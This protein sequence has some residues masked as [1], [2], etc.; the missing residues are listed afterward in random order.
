MTR[1]VYSR[2]FRALRLHIA[3]VSVGFRRWLTVREQFYRRRTGRSGRRPVEPRC[4]PVAAPVL[5][6]RRRRGC[7]CWRWGDD[8]WKMARWKAVRPRRR[9]AE[10]K[11]SMRGKAKASWAASSSRQAIT[12]V[13]RDQG[14]RITAILLE[15]GNL[16]GVIRLIKRHF[17]SAAGGVNVKACIHG[18]TG[19]TNSLRRPK[20]V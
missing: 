9:E 8:E 3:V 20:M 17:S 12:V 14:A 18:E 5:R 7:C 13:L 6:R 15:A 11:R 19:S 2:P 16:R 10:L 1:A 4:P